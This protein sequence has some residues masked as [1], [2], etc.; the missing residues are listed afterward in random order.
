M[1]DPDGTPIWF[2]L[3]PPTRPRR[4]ASTQGPHHGY[5]VWIEPVT[6]DPDGALAF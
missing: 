6:P 2:V 4:S 5:G 3:T 1:Q